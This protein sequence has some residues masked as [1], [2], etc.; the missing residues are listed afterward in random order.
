MKEHGVEP[1]GAGEEGPGVGGGVGDAIGESGR[2]RGAPGASERHDA[3]I[4][5]RHARDQ[6]ELD[7]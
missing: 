6:A 3:R 2:R 1:A 7:E 4:D 5:P